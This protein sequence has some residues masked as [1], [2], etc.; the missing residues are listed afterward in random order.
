M[1]ARRAHNP[2]AAG[3]SPAS[4]TISSVLDGSE[5]KNTRFFMLRGRQASCLPISAMR[6]Y[7]LPQRPAVF[8]EHNRSSPVLRNADGGSYAL[9]RDQASFCKNS[10]SSNNFPAIP[11]RKLA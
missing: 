3:S 4:A 6:G 10:P 2:E 5:V 8:Q 9:L 7:I 1:V 11:N